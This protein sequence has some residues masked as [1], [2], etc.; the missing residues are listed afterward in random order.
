MPSSFC[1]TLKQNAGW[2]ALLL[3]RDG[4]IAE[5]HGSKYPNLIKDLNGVLHFLDRTK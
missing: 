5:K 4:S 2:H 1:I 3:D